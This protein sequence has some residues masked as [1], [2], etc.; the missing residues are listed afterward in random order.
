MEA[1]EGVR[2]DT[3]RPLVKEGEEDVCPSEKEVA[4]TRLIV[5]PEEGKRMLKNLIYI[6]L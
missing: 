2:K 1:E 4:V 6:F 3:P 5:C